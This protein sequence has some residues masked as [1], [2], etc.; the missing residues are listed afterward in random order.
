MS[1]WQ[2]LRQYVDEG[3]D[4]AF[5]QLVDRHK[6]LVYWTCRR[7]IGDMQLAEDAAQAVFITLACRAATIRR[8]ASLAGWLFSVARHVSMRVRATASKFRT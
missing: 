1:D 4:A 5:T 8:D 6:K 2:L 7:D 3:S